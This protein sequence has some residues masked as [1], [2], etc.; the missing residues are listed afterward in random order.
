MILLNLTGGGVSSNPLNTR[1]WGSRNLEVKKFSSL[2]HHLSTKVFAFTM[3]EILISLTIIGVIAAIIIPSLHANIEKKAFATKRKAFYNRISQAMALLN[4]K[5]FNKYG[6]YSASYDGENSSLNVTADTGA[7][8]FLTDGLSKV[9]QINNICDNENF[10]K[11]GMPNTITRNDGAS[12]TSIPKTISELYAPFKNSVSY[13]GASNSPIETNAV[14]FETKNGE[15]AVLYYNP[16]CQNMPQ[17]QISYIMPGVCANIILDLNGKKGPNKVFQDVFFITVFN[18]DSPELVMPI[19]ARTV[20][21]GGTY[22]SPDSELLNTCRTLGSDVKVANSNEAI[23]IAVNSLLVYASGG[24]VGR[25]PW[26]SAIN[27]MPVGRMSINFG[28]GTI[29]P[30]TYYSN[31][32]CL[33]K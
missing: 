6:Q 9:L 31:Y 30:S 27:K 22:T 11:C 24:S 19:V 8:A 32:Y 26:I 4:E 5:S 18:P 13:H 25:Y 10:A 2:A 17:N 14:A 3:A 12:K 20:A 7:M 16:K 1:V 33:K 29:E 28:S 21:D 23:S 15:S